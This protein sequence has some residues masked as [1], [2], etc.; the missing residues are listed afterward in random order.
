MKK[1]L[2]T[3]GISITCVLLATASAGAAA[4]SIPLTGTQDGVFSTKLKLDP[5]LLDFA[6]ERRLNEMYMP[7]SIALSNEKPHGVAK[8][9]AYVGTPQYGVIVLGNGP[10]SAHVFAIDAPKGTQAKIYIDTEGNGDLTSG[11]SGDW[12]DVKVRDG[13]TDYQTTALFRVSYGNP[14][15]ESNHQLYGV[16]LYWADGRSRL[17]YYRAGVPVG[18]ITVNG[19]KFA[20]KVIDQNNEALFNLPYQ[21]DNK[22]T[23]PTYLCL[24]GGRFDARGTFSFGGMNYVAMISPDG[25][26]LT[27]KATSKSITPPTV[28]STKEPELLSVGTKAPDF[29]VPAWGGS[30]V[31]LSSLKGQIVVLDFWATWCGPCKA[32]LP[33]VEKIHER[34]A[35]QNVHVLALNV[36]DDKP[37]YDQWVP[38][39]KQYKFQFAYDPAGRDASSI[40]KSKYR[41]SGIPTTYIIDREGKIAAAILGFNGLDDKRIEAALEKLGVKATPSP[42]AP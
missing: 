42:V 33:H 1:L 23:K 38:A 24:D 16:N 31:R 15:K 13:I 8:E 36:F 14:K 18:E 34:Y 27:L 10:K 26:R 25:T 40:A 5:T 32:S 2:K 29:E 19:E 12:K 21:V 4:P 17:N 39:N 6:G 11:G 7:S 28:V 30:T 20:V 22:P 37:A 35:S 9:P 41:V 3:L